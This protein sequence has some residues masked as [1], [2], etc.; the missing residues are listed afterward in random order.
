M[1][2]LLELP[3]VQDA[4]AKADALIEAL[5]WIRQFR[6]KV[7]VIK[8]GGSVMED[9]DR[10]AT[11]CCSISSLWPPSA[12]G[13]SLCMAAERPSAGR[14]TRPGSNLSSSM[15]VVI[16]MPRR[17]EIVEHVLAGDHQPKHCRPDRTLRRPGHDAQLC[18]Q[19]ECPFGERIGLDGPD[20]EKLD[21]GFVGDVTRVDRA[22]IENLC[23]AGQVPVIPSMC[24][25][26]NGQKYNVNADTAAQA[27]A[28]ALGAEKLVFLSDVNG[29]RSDVNDP[30]SLIQTLTAR[31]PAR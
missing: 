13:R 19:C 14:W 23:Y 26:E 16:P 27:V 12:C 24:I 5:G 1:T 28:E 17:C 7:T 11:I 10:A 8:L 20:G 15:G 31:S 29:V 30:D 4:I 2:L 9:P 21:L 6:D 22:V 25:D 3:A 18:P